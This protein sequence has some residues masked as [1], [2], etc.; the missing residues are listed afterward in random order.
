LDPEGDFTE[1]EVK[2][3]IDLGFK[4]VSLG[5]SRF[6]AETAAIIATHTVSIVNM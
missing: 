6:R 3:A 2:K 1:N 5:K 4:P